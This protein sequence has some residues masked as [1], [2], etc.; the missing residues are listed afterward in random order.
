MFPFSR[1]LVA[2]ARD[3]LDL[4]LLAYAANLLR[5]SPETAVTIAAR[6]PL[7][8]AQLFAPTVRSVFASRRVNH[9]DCRYLTEPDL[10]GIYEA[11]RQSG[12]QLVLARPPAELRSNGNAFGRTVPCAPPA[13]W[14]V[15]EGT[16]SSP[17]HVVAAIDLDREGSS[18]LDTAVRLACA[19]GAA[20]L[21]AAHVFSGPVLDPGTETAD[22]LSETKLLDLYCLM[23]R[24]RQ[25]GVTFSLRVEESLDPP[26][27][28]ARLA[29]EAG[30]DLLIAGSASIDLTAVQHLPVLALPGGNGQTGIRRLARHWRNV[31]G[32]AFN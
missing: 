3:G 10:D 6:P 28:A 1:V 20:G 26:R 17:R 9:V 24:V 21:I 7:K 27:R 32:P 16:N 8:T 31:P 15:P 14:L 13:F 19:V 25:E 29:E 12:T 11:A 4:D 23:S 18:V 2:D 30:A 5:Y 22:R